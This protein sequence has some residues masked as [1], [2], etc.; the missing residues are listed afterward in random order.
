MD[1]SAELDEIKKRVLPKQT[2]IKYFSLAK[3]QYISSYRCSLRIYKKNS[4]FAFVLV[5]FLRID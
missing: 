4:S 2:E 3:N 5:G 1:I